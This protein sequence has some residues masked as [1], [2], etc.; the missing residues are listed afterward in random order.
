MTL[1]NSI[2]DWFNVVNMFKFIFFQ[3]PIHLSIQLVSPN[4][5]DKFQI[6]TLSEEEIVANIRRDPLRDLSHKVERL[7]LVII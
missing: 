3:K 2:I 4:A 1:I 7:R 6:F 5:K